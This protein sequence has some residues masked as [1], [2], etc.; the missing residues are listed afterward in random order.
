MAFTQFSPPPSSRH[1][2]DP[3]P[4]ADAPLLAV[5]FGQVTIIY[6]TGHE[7][8][9]GGS[10]GSDACRSREPMISDE[11]NPFANA[12]PNCKKIY[13]DHLGRARFTH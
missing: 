2:P 9:G 5:E 7:R 12:F 4:V 8:L 13:S 10:G 1:R 6:R 3:R 11:R